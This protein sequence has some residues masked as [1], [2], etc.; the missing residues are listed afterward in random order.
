MSSED[1]FTMNAESERNF[2]SIVS[3]N[4]RG[5][6]SVK[7]GFLNSLLLR[8]DI[9]FIQEHWLSDKQL[10]D[11]NQIN[12]QFLCHAVCGFD[13]SDILSGRP[14]GGCAILWRSDLR[15]RIEPVN[16][17]S[18]RVCAICMR[19][20]SWSVLFINVYMPY[21]DGEKR[22]DDF[23]SQLT[24]IEYLIHQHPDCHIVLGGDF[25]VDFSRN[26]FHTELLTDFCDNLSLEPVYQH[27]K[28]CID[29]SYNFN[30]SRFNVLDH[31]ILS[32]ILF[33]NAIMSVD[34]IH[35]GDNLSDHEPIVM[36]LRLDNK[37]VCLSEKIYCDKIAWYKAEDCHITEYQST[38][39]DMLH[40]VKIPVE[41][42]ACDYPLC[43]NI[44]H[45]IELNA[46]ANAITDACLATANAAFPHTSRCGRKPMPGWT[47][48]VEPYRSKSIFWHN[49]WIECGRP[50]TGAVADI[51]RRT[52]ASYHYAVRR[53][54]KNEQEIVRQRFAEAVLCNN[55]RDLWSEVR[56]INGNRAAPAST[57]DGQ[58]SPDCISRIFTDKYKQL[59]NSVPYS[60]HE[61]IDIRNSIEKRIS[62]GDYSEDCRVSSSEI[63]AAITRL[64]PNKND[65]GRG[66]STNHF[67]FACTE[68]A[69]HTACL[70]SGLLVH[71]SAIDDFLCSTTVPIPKGRNVNLTVSENYRGITLSSVFGRIFDLIVLNR[72]SD[73]LESCELQFGFKQN[74]STAMCSMIAKEVIAYY[75]SCHT[76]VHCVF[77]DSS[78]AFD[79]IHYGKLFKLLLN[80]DIPPYVIRVLLNMYTDQQIRVLW[81]GKY[82][83]CF[84]VNNGVKQ[85]AI[86]SPILF[87]VYLDVLLSELQKAG[88]GCFIGTWFA[89]ALAYADDLILMAP[90][91]RAMRGMLAICDKFA[92]EYSVTFNNTKSKCI[93][94]HYSKAGRDACAPLP[95]FA[96]GGNVI[97]NVDRWPH[98]GHV[99]NACFTD[100]DDILA[101]RTSFIGQANSF[102][103]N[104]PM[105]D[106]ETKN[107]LFKVYCSSHYGSELWNLTN[108]NLE[109]YCIAWRKSLRR[110]WSLPYNSSQLSTA[111]TS[112]T[113]PLFDEICRRVTNFIYSCLHCDSRFIRS[114]VLHGI[115][116]SR[117]N[118]PIGRNAA[119]CSLHFDTHIDSLFDAKLGGY[120]C[121]A[122][123][124]SKLSTDLV[125]RANALR[126]AILIRDG[127]FVFSSVNHLSINDLNFL[128]ESLAVNLN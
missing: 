42:I 25:N 11:L 4:C 97:E 18:R 9:L 93:T 16:T 114:I 30:M 111:L 125:A 13:N 44:N 79:K 96:I 34:A 103:C 112:L 127:S 109:V 101:R 104:F 100:D 68:L 110:L 39:R 75:T 41:A 1:S 122:R 58:S 38:L 81:N 31:F 21:E 33:E 56:R 50:K 73:K 99:F 51:M 126:E 3:Y 12:T 28:Y 117:A 102:F 47:E 91:A 120:Y 64:K 20:D 7:S 19:T 23:C 35:C 29:Y 67:K 123:F 83:T 36:N 22:S 45:S 61:M 113:I 49:I 88:L 17:G 106:V 66:L 15:A 89:A 14:Y 95:S 60:T 85:G 76:S 78:K 87:C 48:Y 107:S 94:F 84:S 63:T 70:F 8:C 108:T 69:V 74:R 116:V 24:T 26:W 115:Q 43:K 27:N 32:G 2:L 77:L 121:F 124:K 105:L 6:N 55:N 52:R 54:K 82:S 98:L 65:G 10:S 71:G 128:I 86:V 57:I 92:K 90:S 46:Y 53:V 37:L 5:F 40:S 118:S 72:Y 119:F 62:S 59:Y 80:R